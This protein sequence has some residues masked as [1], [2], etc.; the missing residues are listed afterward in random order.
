M[1][2]LAGVITKGFTERE[3]LEADVQREEECTVNMKG[4]RIL[5]DDITI[6]VKLIK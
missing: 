6:K 3:N 4:N 1:R 5:G 2:T